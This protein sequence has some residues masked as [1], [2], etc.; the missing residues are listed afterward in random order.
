[1]RM[2]K[3]RIRLRPRKL[4]RSLGGNIVIFILVA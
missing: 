4:N 2:K 1:M 3:F